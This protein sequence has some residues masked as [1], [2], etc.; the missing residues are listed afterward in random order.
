MALR[1]SV[2][3]LAAVNAC[4]VA[5]LSAVWTAHAVR[6]YLIRKAAEERFLGGY[7]FSYPRFN[8]FLRSKKQCAAAFPRAPAAAAAR[9]AR[10]EPVP[11][12]RPDFSFAR[13]PWASFAR[14]SSPFWCVVACF[15]AWPGSWAHRAA[16]R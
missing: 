1:G 3:F 8:F 15:P 11:R 2:I 14:S 12:T 10:A 5:L 16:T 7:N 4:L 6:S 13:P 9:R